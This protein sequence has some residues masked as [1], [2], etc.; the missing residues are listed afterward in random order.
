MH[1]FS[2]PVEQD[3]GMVDIVLICIWTLCP[4]GGSARKHTHMFTTLCLYTYISKRKFC[5]SRG[6]VGNISIYLQKS[7]AHMGTF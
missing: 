3:S 6:S 1:M 4:S 7:C 2:P 5:S